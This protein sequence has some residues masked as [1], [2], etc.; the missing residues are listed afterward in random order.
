[1]RSTTSLRQVHPAQHG[2]VA[3]VSSQCCEHRVRLYVDYS[4]IPLLD[5][6]IQLIESL[7]AFAAVGVGLRDLHGCRVLVR[8]DQVAGGLVAASARGSLT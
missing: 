4:G 3:D 6:S 5:G 7:G 1:M 8:L 2:F